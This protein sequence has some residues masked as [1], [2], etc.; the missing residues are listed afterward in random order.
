MIKEMQELAAALKTKVKAK[1]ADMDQKIQQISE[2]ILAVLKVFKQPVVSG[3][4]II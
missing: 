3:N 4:K 2:D 1:T